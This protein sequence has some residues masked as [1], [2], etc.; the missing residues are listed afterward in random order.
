[1]QLVPHREAARRFAKLASGVAGVRRVVLF[2]S[3][4]RGTVRP[5]SDVDVAVVLD[6]RTE[7]TLDPIYDAAA[8]I[9]DETGL[10]VVPVGV[11]RRE[12]EADTPFARSLREGEVLY[13]RR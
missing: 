6:R 3:A 9:R 13:E 4:A 2:G 1:V 5:G 8:R 7:A 12:L 10:K 11:V